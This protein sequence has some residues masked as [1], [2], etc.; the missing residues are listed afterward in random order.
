MTSRDSS[1]RTDREQ[2]AFESMSGLTA[3]VLLLVT[4]ISLVPIAYHFPESRIFV[5]FIFGVVILTAV[6]VRADNGDD[7]ND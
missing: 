2:E 5:A 4:L 1:H 3:L 7:Q 6:L